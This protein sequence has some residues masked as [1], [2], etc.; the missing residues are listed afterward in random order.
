MLSSS[1]G[2]NNLKERVLLKTC[3]EGLPGRTSCRR[4]LINV[5]DLISMT[6]ESNLGVLLAALEL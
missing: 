4:P 2:R 1:N 5:I 3:S 6:I